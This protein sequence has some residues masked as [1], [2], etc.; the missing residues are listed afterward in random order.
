MPLRLALVTLELL[1]RLRDRSGGVAHFRRVGPLIARRRRA[2]G[3]F[4]FELVRPGVYK[5]KSLRHNT[6]GPAWPSKIGLKPQVHP[7]TG[8]V[9]WLP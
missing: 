6:K 9:E 1:A 2:A 4:A 5:I 3:H 8:V 7:T